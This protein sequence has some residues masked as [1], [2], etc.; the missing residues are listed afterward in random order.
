ME[1]TPLTSDKRVRVFIV[2]DS[3]YSRNRSKTLELLARVHEHTTG[4]FIKGFSMLTLGW[5]DGFGFV[6]L[7]FN[8]LSSRKPKNPG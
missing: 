7:D 8:L 6:P 3:V 2:D 1:K 5:S 4:K